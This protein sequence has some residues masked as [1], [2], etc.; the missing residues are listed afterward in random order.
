MSRTLFFHRE[1]CKEGA[2]PYFLIG[3]QMRNG[4]MNPYRIP[5]PGK[6]FGPSWGHLGPPWGPLGVS[7]IRR[8][9]GWERRVQRGC[10]DP[11]VLGDLSGHFGPS[12]GVLGPSWGILGSSWGILGPS[13]PHLGRPGRPVT[14][15]INAIQCVFYCFC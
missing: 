15:K 10:S 7:Y 5:M 6:R 14:D 1:I 4:H 13:W 3:K 2:E 9:V 12:W 8:K 11:A